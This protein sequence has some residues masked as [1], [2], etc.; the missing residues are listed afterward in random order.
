VRGQDVAA[1]GA[2]QLLQDGLAPLSDRIREH[3]AAHPQSDAFGAIGEHL[4]SL[5][6]RGDTQRRWE[7][8]R[9]TSPDGLRT[10]LQI[11]P[12]DLRLL[13]WEL[14]TLHR[15]LFVDEQHP[16]LRARDLGTDPAQLLLPLRLLVVEGQHDDRI[17]TGVE[18]RAIKRALAESAGHIEAEFLREPS[19]EMLRRTYE[20]F[21]PHVFHFI[22]HGTHVAGSAEPGLRVVDG[23]QG[24]TW[25]LTRRHFLNLLTPAPRVAVLNACRSGE[26]A[27]VRDLTDAFFAGGTAAVIGM[28]GDVKG[29]AAARFGGE[30]YKAV[31][32]EELIDEAVARARKEVYGDVGVVQQERDWFLPSLTVRVPPEQVLPLACAL[33]AHEREGV[34]LRF[35]SLI[36]PF[37]DRV[38]ER[39][40]L[41]EGIDPEAGTNPVRLIVLAGD[42]YAGKTR[43]LHWIRRRCALRGR[44]VKYVDFRGQGA[45]D[46]LPA[47]CMIRDT[48]EDVPSLGAHAAAAFARFD[49]D[50]TFLA[51]GKLPAEPEGALPV[52]D[53]VPNPA[54][55]PDGPVSLIDRTFQSFREAL[56]AATAEQPLVLVLDH[57][58]GLLRPGFQHQ[59]F[60]RLIRK[61]V[62]DGD[63]PNLRLV[64]V[65]SSEQRRD[66][67]PADDAR[68]GRWIEVDS[69]PL[70]RYAAL[71]EDLLLALAIDVDV[72]HEALIE[73]AA[74]FVKDP[75]GLK[76]LMTVRSLVQG[77]R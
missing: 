46:F 22:G 57:L 9:Y 48:A 47:L 63:A 76:E 3:V 56:G 15:E 4:A 73:A 41:V 12:T 52:V 19:E 54:A 34:D 65:L 6:L 27:A 45:T 42:A 61:V 37:V 32:R 38:E 60:P 58:D 8:L 7:E 50:L 43:I 20:R 72:R 16:V 29:K 11:E 39:H 70:G 64:V 28:Q 55:L 74:G 5:L 36:D 2:P 62:V 77:M 66:L 75:W 30:L 33:P 71:A 69:I 23:A 24:T 51:Q 67:W 10:L 44:R 53:P 18:V 31:A 40:R 35:A 1:A 14:M 13:P 21:R 59:L 68:L 26:V 25:V 49:Y 17:G